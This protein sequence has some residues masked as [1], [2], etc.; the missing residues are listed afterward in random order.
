MKKQAL[1]LSALSGLCCTLPIQAE[2][3][4]DGLTLGA[5]YHFNIEQADNGLYNPSET[6]ESLNQGFDFVRL[7]A[8]GDLSDKTSLFMR[9]NLSKSSLERFNLTHK[10]TD[11]ISV[12][13]GLQKARVFGWHRR[14]SSG[15][16]ATESRYVSSSFRP[17]SNTIMLQ[18][19][20]KYDFGKFTVQVVEDYVECS[21]SPCTSWNQKDEN[22][23]VVRTQPGVLAEWIGSFGAFKPLVQ[24]GRYDLGKSYTA[25][26]GL[27]Y[28]KNNLDLHTDYV[29]DERLKRGSSVAG[30]TETTRKLVGMTVQANY[31]F[32]DFTPYA[33]L[34]SFEVE[35][36]SGG[37]V[38]Q[39]ALN[40][41]T[42]SGDLDREGQTLAVGAYY[43]GLGEYARPYLSFSTKSGD[44]SVGE[45]EK[46]LTTTSVT[47][48]V[49][50]IL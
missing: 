3:K 25:T 21:N 45:G 13:A 26:V 35:D 16:L 31:R 46:T 22:D 36:T 41:S 9:Y 29:M 17:F 38:V 6:K 32:G 47:A 5:M 43:D 44:Y 15:L 23:N 33:H 39:K 1:L 34:S 30:E 40:T 12:L 28:K 8:K 20:A 18:L 27:R 24:Y 50:G 4:F 37:V 42:S 14:I 7:I 11:K 49:V 19:E 10:L 2:T 48:G